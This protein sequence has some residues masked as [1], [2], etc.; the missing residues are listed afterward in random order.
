MDGEGAVHATVFGG[1]R[2]TARLSHADGPSLVFG[3]WNDLKFMRDGESVWLVVNGRAGEKVPFANYLPNS[4]WTSIGTTGD[5]T[6]FK[7]FRGEIA[8]L[9]VTLLSDSAVGKD[10]RPEPNRI[11]MLR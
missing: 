1:R 11:G 3:K 6:D 9:G 4:R 7:F 2:V 8:S 5:K 10:K